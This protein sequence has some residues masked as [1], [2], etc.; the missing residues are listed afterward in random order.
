MKPIY[1]IDGITLYHGDCG[2]VLPQLKGWADLCLTDPPYGIDLDASYS[3]FKNA[4]QYR[5]VRGDDKAFDAGMLLDIAPKLIVWGGNC[6]ASTLPDFPGWLAW[7]KTGRN[8]AKIR[9]AEME[10]AWTNFVTR[11]QA[12]RFTWIGA[13][14]EGA[15]LVLAHPTQKPIQLMRWCLSLAPEAEKIID[16][17]AGSG[18]TLVAAK[19]MGRRAIGIE[20]DERYCQTI[21]QRLGQTE[22]VFDKS[23]PAMI[24]TNCT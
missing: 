18:T 1:D 11:S 10:L 3:K 17:F 24:S 14:R 13:Y 12:F 22:M 19:E 9:Q 5:T 20:I 23:V 15:K 6:F 21:I 16:P 7:V 8:G 2:E 4:T